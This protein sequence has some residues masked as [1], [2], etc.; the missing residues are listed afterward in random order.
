MGNKQKNHSFWTKRNLIIVISAI[1]V[2]A[3]GI[4]VMVYWIIQQNSTTN[5]PSPVIDAAKAAAEVKQ[6]NADGKLRDEAAAQIKGKKTSVADKL[7]QEA[8]D[9]EGSTE[10][11]TRLYLDLSGVYYAAEQYKE[12]FEAAEKAESLNPDKFLVADW[13]SR[14]Y[15]DQKNYTKAA[16]YYT[17]AGQWVSS[18]ENKTALDKQYFDGKAA[19]MKKLGEA[20]K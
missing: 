5:E 14:L 9:A 20:K 11:K 16:E 10:R 1:S 19:E 12:A 15:E 2:F 13:L 6:A 18:K 4:G 7:Y 3:L 17:L 8:I